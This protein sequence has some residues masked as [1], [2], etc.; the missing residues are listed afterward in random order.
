M[1][2]IRTIIYIYAHIPKKKKKAE[3]IACWKVFEHEKRSLGRVWLLH[4]RCLAD[5]D[6]SH[7]LETARTIYMYK[8]QNK[9]ELN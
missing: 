1:K 8:H 7:L 6:N 9:G 4:P 3:R 5:K 2:N